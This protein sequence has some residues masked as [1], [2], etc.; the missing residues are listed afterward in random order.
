MRE[1]GREGERMSP[2]RRVERGARSEGVREG[3]RQRDWEGGWWDIAWPA[4]Y[5]PDRKSVV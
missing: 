1:G 2:A 5:E 4:P 3:R